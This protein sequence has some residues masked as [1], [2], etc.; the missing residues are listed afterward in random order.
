MAK[1]RDRAWTGNDRRRAEGVEDAGGA[2]PGTQGMN[3]A[4]SNAM[5]AME[6]DIAA[7]EDDQETA[8]DIFAEASDEDRMHASGG[9]TQQLD[10]KSGGPE[11]SPR[12]RPR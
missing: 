2:E 12:I 9:H 3:F 11:P 1:K 6:G 10:E 4:E 8:P 7:W 5:Y